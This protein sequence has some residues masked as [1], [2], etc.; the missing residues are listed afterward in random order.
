MFSTCRKEEL[1]VKQH[2]KHSKIAAGQLFYIGVG[3]PPQARFADLR[4]DAVLIGP[5][6]PALSSAD[7]A[8]IPPE[9]LADPVWNIAG[10]GAILRRSP[11]DQSTCAH[12]GEVMQRSSSVVNGRCNFYEPFGR[13]NSWRV[14][15]ADGN[16]LPTAGGTYYAAV[17][18]QSHS[19]GKVGIALGTW[20][21]NFWTPHPQST[22]ACT[23][24]IIDFSEEK[25]GD[26]SD[27]FPVQQ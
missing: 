20:V 7:R 22:P 13:T 15:D 26:Q 25:D 16:F 10:V 23:R 18:L 8:L 27:C 5:G 14:L 2:I 6:L 4:A 17:F 3:I 1:E 9:V 11:A 24:E 19:S 12:L 21:E